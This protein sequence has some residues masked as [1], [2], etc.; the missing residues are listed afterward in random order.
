MNQ[1][2]MITCHLYPLVDEPKKPM[3]WR[4]NLQPTGV[5]SSHSSFP[6]SLPTFSKISSRP[7]AR[8]RYSENQS[9]NLPVCRGKAMTREAMAPQ[10]LRTKFIE[11]PQRNLKHVER[12]QNDQK[13]MAFPVE[14]SDDNPVPVG[15]RWS[16]APELG[17]RTSQKTHPPT[18][19][20]WSRTPVMAPF[21]GPNDTWFIGLVIL[22]C[23]FLDWLIGL[24]CWKK[25]NAEY[26]LQN[27]PFAS[28]LH[29]SISFVIGSVMLNHWGLGSGFPHCWTT[30]LWSESPRSFFCLLSQGVQFACDVSARFFPARHSHCT[31][32]VFHAANAN[33]GAPTM[34][35]LHPGEPIGSNTWT[36]KNPAIHGPFSSGSARKVIFPGPFFG[37]S[38]GP[39]FK[40]SISWTFPP[41]N[42]T[43]L[44]PS[45]PQSSTPRALACAVRGGWSVKSPGKVIFRLHKWRFHQPGMG[46]TNK[47]HGVGCN[48]LEPEHYSE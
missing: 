28:V 39:G 18:V 26:C 33:V 44:V 41:G 20:W 40:V 1:Y 6:P 31:T 3:K 43:P 19:V 5:F 36:S 47:R 46:I 17:P 11:I 29:L 34:E 4:T 7:A 10:W 48:Q 35:P 22:I 38:R 15:V 32:L 8:R 21:V 14:F 30:H 9:Y 45:A 24:V 25:N 2:S 13:P 37:G 12:D 23:R 42:A 16:E 27:R